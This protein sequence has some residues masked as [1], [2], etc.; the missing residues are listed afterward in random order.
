MA[1]LSSKF[2]K[3]GVC[4]N[5]STLIIDPNDLMQGVDYLAWFCLFCL[6]VCLFFHSG[7]MSFVFLGEVLVMNN[8]CHIF[9]IC[10]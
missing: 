2:R 1:Q 3:N 9:F 10:Q 5:N 4:N 7:Q 8:I 6:F